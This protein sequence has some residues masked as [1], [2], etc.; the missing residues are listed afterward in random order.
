MS[1][2]WWAQRESNPQDDGSKPPMY[3]S[4]S[5]VPKSSYG[6]GRY[7]KPK[8]IEKPLGRERA[9]GQQYGRTIEIDPRQK[10][11][12]YLE[13][14]IHE[15]LHVYFRGADETKVTKV[16]KLMAKTLWKLRFRRLAK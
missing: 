2:K 5:H 16:A 12:R 13:T 6:V 10:P 14:A 3:S 4:S 11:K 1:T 9:W 8:V 7:K 15:M